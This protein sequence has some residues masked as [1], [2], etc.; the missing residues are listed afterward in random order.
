[1]RCASRKWVVD[2]KHVKA[3]QRA[4]LGRGVDARNGRVACTGFTDGA[5]PSVVQLSLAQEM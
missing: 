1:M 5:E 4:E 2:R 3:I